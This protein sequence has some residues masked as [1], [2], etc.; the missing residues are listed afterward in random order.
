[1]KKIFTSPDY[2]HLTDQHP[3]LIVF[4]KTATQALD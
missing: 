3:R 2:G 1:M 4:M